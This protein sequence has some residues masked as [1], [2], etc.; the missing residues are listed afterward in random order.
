MVS[1]M[2]CVNDH[3][4]GVFDGLCRGISLDDCEQLTLESPNLDRHLKCEIGASFLRLGKMRQWRHYGAKTWVGNWCWDAVALS[5]EDAADVLNF[6]IAKGYQATVMTDDISAKIG[7]CEPLVAED[8]T[9]EDAT[10]ATTSPRAGRRCAAAT[11]RPVT[12]SGQPMAGPTPTI[13]AGINTVS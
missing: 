5:P 13:L 8:L 6:A 10:W 2:L 1:L 11:S 7:A 9:G 3:R 12:A 4:N